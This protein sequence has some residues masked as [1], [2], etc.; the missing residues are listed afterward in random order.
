MTSREFFSF[1]CN[2]AHIWDGT[3]GSHDMMGPV[4]IDSKSATFFKP[5]RTWLGTENMRLDSIHGCFPLL[6]SPLVFEIFPFL[7]TRPHSNPR[8]GQVH[9]R[10][11]SHKLGTFLFWALTQSCS[12][13]NHYIWDVTS[14]HF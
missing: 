14:G 10:H 11:S 4:S 9:F 12:L 7:S 3:S 13:R 5:G 2:L 1:C 8:P 6:D